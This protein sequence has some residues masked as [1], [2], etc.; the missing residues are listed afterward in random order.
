[1]GMKGFDQ[2]LALIE[3]VSGFQILDRDL[4]RMEKFIAERIA[5]S[6]RRS[7]DSYL[8]LLLQSPWGPEW[9]ALLAKITI[10]ESFL[11]RGRRQLGRFQEAVLPRLAELRAGSRTIRV[12]SAGCARGE[13]PATLALLLVENRAFRGWRWEILGVDVDEEALAAARSGVFGSRA[14]SRVPGELR[15]R[16]FT[17]RGK[18]SFELL[19]GLKKHLSFER[20]NLVSGTS[21]FAEGEF[22]VVFL[23]NVLIYFGR[24]AQR[25]VIE[26]AA[27][28]LA[29]DGW[30]FLG[31]SETLWPISKVLAPVDLGDCFAYRHPASSTED[32]SSEGAALHGFDPEGPK[33]ADH[34]RDDAV[35]G[36]P[37][38]SPRQGSAHR[39]ESVHV[40]ET[41]TL[42]DA[43]RAASELLRQGK[44]ESCLRRVDALVRST[45][46]LPLIH[47]LRGM[48]Q[49]AGGQQAGA[50]ESFRAAL[51]LDPRLFQV[52][53]LLAESFAALGL[54]ERADQEYRR[55]LGM[56]AAK[57]QG[58]LPEYDLYG[59]PGRQEIQGRCELFLGR[60]QK[61]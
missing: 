27:R 2:I 15:R 41:A 8:S 10:K 56:L 28:V 7:M 31:P 24:S 49:V 5:A 33:A 21:P 47:A 29:P 17:K 60:G 30:L 16:Y 51:Y 44:V 1:M 35:L 58:G 32:R 22:D 42:E 19:P 50:V 26:D 9:R 54:F 38:E 11:F 57:S 59:F 39:P 40:E 45:A 4:A 43:I 46:D 53:F 61:P 3:Q 14:M 18:E 52:R 13:E 34:L 20:V 6:G 55:V 36:T 23:R 37:G 25:R 48:A 12:L